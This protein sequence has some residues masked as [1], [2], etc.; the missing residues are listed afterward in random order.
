MCQ[1]RTAVDETFVPSPMY[2]HTIMAVSE[3][4]TLVSNGGTGSTHLP[5]V[6]N[7][8]VLLSVASIVGVFLPVFNVNVCNTA[9]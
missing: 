8:F 3:K 7:H 1:L 5:E 6:L 4:T 9:N 2:A